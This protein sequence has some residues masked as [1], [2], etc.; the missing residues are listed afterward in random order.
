MDPVEF[1]MPEGVELKINPRQ[2]LGKTEEKPE[3]LA[4]LSPESQAGLRQY[5]LERMTGYGVDYADAVELRAR[6]VSGEDWQKAAEDLALGALD[7]ANSLTSETSRA[8]LNHRASALLR[9]SQALMLHDTDQRREI[10]QRAVDSYTTAT[11]L[12][13]KR[14]HVDIATPEGTMSGWFVEAAGEEA[15]GSA[16]VIGG[17]EGWAMDF[18]GLGEEMAA[19]GIDTLLLDAPGQGETRILN[20]H[21]LTA[22][23]MESFRRAIDF[24]EQRTRGKPI[25][26]VGNSMGGAITIAMANNDTRVA[27]CINNG[28]IFRPSLARMAG[29][30]FFQKM[31]AFTGLEGDDAEHRAAEIWDTIEPLRPGLNSNYPL[32][33]VQGGQDML[34]FDDHAKI[35]MALTPAGEKEMEYFSDGIHCIYNHLSDR[36]IVMSDWMRARLLDAGNA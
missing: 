20:G 34:V 33:V 15:I 29:P 6:I 32:L 31:V 5:S 24:C 4:A 26:L 17:V 35:F 21:F 16:I 36:D 22:K 3:A 25:G 11:K 19:R 23:W 7:S 10:V 28:G 14:D 1:K 2:F 30:T 18:D 8:R 9:M 13:S 12:G 27:A